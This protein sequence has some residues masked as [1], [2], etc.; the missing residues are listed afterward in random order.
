MSVQS[1]WLNTKEAAEYMRAPVSTI[2]HY[3]Q[4]NMIPFHKPNGRIL[5]KASDLDSFIEKS[6]RA[7]VSE[8]FEKNM[9]IAKKS[10]A[11]AHIYK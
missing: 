11:I 1:P 4:N 2:Y 10:K 6:R 8:S 7:P 3:I 9:N 5:F